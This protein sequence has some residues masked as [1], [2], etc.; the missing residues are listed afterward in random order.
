MILLK[1][2]CLVISKEEGEDAK[3]M[4]EL[5]V[6]DGFQVTSAQRMKLHV[7]SEETQGR[8]IIPGN[9]ATTSIT[10]HGQIFLKMIRS[11]K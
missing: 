2:K 5:K 1:V 10:C 9:V 6:R 11:K 3:L 7:E 8:N 4:M